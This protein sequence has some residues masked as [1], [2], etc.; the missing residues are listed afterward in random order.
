MNKLIEHLDE[1]RPDQV[2][3]IQAIQ[4]SLKMAS[5]KKNFKEHPAMLLLIDTLRKREKGYTI[6]LSDKEDLSQEKR[7]AYFA[8][9]AEV[10]W[11]LAFFDVDQT[12]ESIE[13][14]LDTELDLQLSG[15]V[16]SEV[17]NP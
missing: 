4:K 6:V 11:I 8:R 14:R 17:V 1:Y 7:S 15:S 3:E 5:L 9:R 12:I 2:P 16:D 13:R 10:R